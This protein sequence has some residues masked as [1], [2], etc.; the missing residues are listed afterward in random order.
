MRRRLP[1]RLISKD[2]QGRS[3]EVVELPGAS[4]PDKASDADQHDPQR[5]R[6]QNE[7]DRHGSVRK[8]WLR[9]ASK[10]TVTE[11]TGIMIAAISGLM[12]PVTAKAAP[13]RL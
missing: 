13:T 4:G 11:L 8:V 2:P 12:V 1:P 10:M 7:Q 5:H 6:H 3:V 9:H